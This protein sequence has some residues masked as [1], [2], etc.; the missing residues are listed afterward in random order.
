MPAPTVP[1]LSATRLARTVA[2]SSTVTVAFTAALP[3]P[4][5]IEV[6]AG[7]LQIDTT[8]AGVAPSTSF[9]S[10]RSQLQS[11]TATGL[12]VAGASRL[13]HSRWAAD[14]ADSPPARAAWLLDAARSYTRAVGRLPWARLFLRAAAQHLID[15][16]D[17]EQT[18]ATVLPLARFGLLPKWVDYQLRHAV[19][20]HFGTDLVASLES[21][22]A[23]VA[24]LEDDEAEQL[25]DYGQQ[26]VDLL[27]PNTRHTADDAPTAGSGDSLRAAAESALGEVH[28][29]AASESEAQ[30]H[31][32]GEPATDAPTPLARIHGEM[33]AASASVFSR[34]SLDRITHRRPTPDDLRQRATIVRRL[35]RAQYEAP[36]RTSHAVTYPVGRANSSALV[37]RAAQRALRQ[38]VTATPWRRTRLAASPKPPLRVGVVV[39]HSGSMGQWLQQSGTVIW[40]LAAAVDQLGGSAAAAAFAGDVIPVLTAASAPKMVPE[41]P[42][43]GGSSGCDTAISAVAHSA[44]LEEPHG[45]RALIVLTDGQL[46]RAASAPINR[47]CTHLLRSGVHVVWALVIPRDSADVIPAGATVIDRVDPDRFGAM[48][49]A[50]LVDAL[51]RQ[52]R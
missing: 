7:R 8:A 50:S 4:L 18:V 27:R 48:V 24:I 40:S 29:D 12:I 9:F 14:A 31:R 45:A 25:L 2:R 36:S 39:D 16:A 42:V 15:V 17:P 41:M 1:E 49:T 43:T 11:P 52:R 51:T 22:T 34:Q 33:A 38:P 10:L 32:R 19:E 23:A 3:H 46:P 35:R 47:Y 5:S 37:Q 30:G 13:V 26:W 20:D 44:R 28:D 6:A 21:V